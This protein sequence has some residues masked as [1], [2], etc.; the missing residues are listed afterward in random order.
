MGF[1]TLVGQK[2]V[3]SGDIW[4]G[5]ARAGSVSRKEVAREQTG[6]DN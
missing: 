3:L 1:T 4:R 2:T 5:F 6:E